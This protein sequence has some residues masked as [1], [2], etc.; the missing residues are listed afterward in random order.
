MEFAERWVRIG[1]G[2]DLMADMLDPR[3]KQDEAA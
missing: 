3:G 1:A 2:G